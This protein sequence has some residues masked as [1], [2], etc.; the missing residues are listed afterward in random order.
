MN[1]HKRSLY[2]DLPASRLVYILHKIE[3]AERSKFSESVTINSALTLE[4]ILPRTWA[5]TWPLKNGQHPNVE[6][7]EWA[8]RQTV[9]GLPLDA[10]SQEISTRE[11]VVD[12][13]GNLT[14]IVGRLNSSVSNNPFAEKRTAILQHSTLGLNR[15]FHGVD[16]WDEAEIGTRSEILFETARTLWPRPTGAHVS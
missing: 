12:T 10:L 5:G 16:K 14:L 4:H 11:S 15:Y 1:F 6:Q 7:I 9:L 3:D 13:L 2:R 8:K